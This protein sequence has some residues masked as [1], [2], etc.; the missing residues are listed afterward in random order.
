MKYIGDSRACLEVNQRKKWHMAARRQGRP[1]RI[2]RLPHQLP[3]RPIQ[4]LRRQ[5]IHPPAEQLP[6][7]LD[8]IRRLPF[9]LAR[10][11]EPDAGRGNRRRSAPMLASPYKHMRGSVP[12]QPSEKAPGAN[13]KR[14][15]AQHRRQKN[16]RGYDAPGQCQSVGKIAVPVD[17]VQRET[18]A[19][20]PVNGWALLPAG[21]PLAPSEA[22]PLRPPVRTN[23]SRTCYS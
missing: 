2:D 6:H 7:Q 1:V 10:R 18:A 4:S 21:A 11:V 23:P 22:Q 16:A 5:R 13:A 17:A 9:A 14:T 20:H 3:H 19:R 15:A 8:R 12:Q